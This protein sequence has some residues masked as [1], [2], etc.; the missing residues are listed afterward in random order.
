MA[1]AGRKRKPNRKRYPNGRAKPTTP[2]HDKG[3]DGTQR[4]RAAKEA[5]WGV[6][7][8][9]AVDAPGRA[10]AGVL[11]T[12]LERDALRAFHYAYWFTLPGGYPPG[13][14]K[15]FQPEVRNMRVGEWLT[16]DESDARDKARERM[17]ID[18]AKRIDAM[19]IHVR[20]AFDMVATEWNFDEGPPWLDRLLSGKFHTGDRE[21]MEFCRRAT[22]VLF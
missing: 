6:R 11:I 13:T 1:K 5:Q 22:Q 20:R 10:W 7:A 16:E 21:M 14:L 15:Q 9:E 2:R 8:G 12:D 17:I 3:S 18:T 4:R 19:G